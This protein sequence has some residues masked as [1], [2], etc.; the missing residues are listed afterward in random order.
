MVCEHIWK[1]GHWADV[2]DPATGLPYFGQAGSHIYSDVHGN[3]ALLK[4]ETENVGGCV[5][6]SH[7]EWKYA[8]YPATLFSS[9]PLDVLKEALSLT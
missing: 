2:T 7:P 3:M 9:A 1:H 8:S 4:Y 6:M 5:V